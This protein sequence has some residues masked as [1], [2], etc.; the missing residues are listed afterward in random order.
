[1]LTA[2][3]YAARFLIDGDMK[4]VELFRQRAA[5]LI[6]DVEALQ[7]ELQDPMLKRMANEALESTRKYLPAF[8]DTVE[9][10]NAVNQL[11][12][13]MGNDAAEFAQTAEVTKAAALDTLART[14]TEIDAGL[15]R[16]TNTNI[17]VGVISVLVGLLL[18]WLV[19]RSI[20]GPV[21]AMT[22]TMTNL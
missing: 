17:V 3:L 14:M 8:N 7:A 5:Q 20:V 16:T 2:R 6:A 15:N 11:V 22:G 13:Q 12:A 1:V 21:R 19:T 18:A 10:A 4:Y 9:A